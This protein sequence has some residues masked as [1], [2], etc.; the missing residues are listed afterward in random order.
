MLTYYILFLFLN[1]SSNSPIIL[2]YIK[3]KILFQQKYKIYL[4]K[5]IMKHLICL[6]K[7]KKMHYFFVLLSV[8][9]KII[10]KFIFRLYESIHKSGSNRTFVI[11]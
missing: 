8:V 1:F 2:I 7:N 9:K 4:S 3:Y 6:K 10:L 11:Y 5:I